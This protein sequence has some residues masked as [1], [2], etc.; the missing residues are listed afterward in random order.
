MVHLGQFRLGIPGKISPAGVGSAPGDSQNNESLGS[1]VEDL[2]G[3]L[4]AFTKILVASQDKSVMSEM[5][6][7]AATRREEIGSRASRRL[8]AEGR[9]PAVLYGHNLDPELLSLDLVEFKTL[10]RHGAH[11]L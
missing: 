11:G 5:S 10:L 3:R 1:V 9:V 2:G 4:G 7:I 6:S 8:R